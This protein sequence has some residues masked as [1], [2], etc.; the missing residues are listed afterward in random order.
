MNP[1]AM[2]SG[3]PLR[4]LVDFQIRMARKERI[5]EKLFFY[6]ILSVKSAR[7]PMA[8]WPGIW[9]FLPV[10]QGPDAGGTPSENFE[11]GITDDAEIQSI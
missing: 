11:E 5:R 3:R 2:D 6:A 10:K 4:A 8:W 9:Y 1:R 7:Q